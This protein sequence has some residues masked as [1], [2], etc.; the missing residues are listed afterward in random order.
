MPQLA[1][2]IVTVFEKESDPSVSSRLVARHVY[3]QTSSR[4]LFS[5]LID[6]IIF[7]LEDDRTSRAASLTWAAFVIHNTESPEYTRYLQ[8]LVKY[9]LTS[10]YN[11][12]R[13]EIGVQRRK[14]STYALMYTSIF[15]N[16]IKINNNLFDVIQEIYSSLLSQEMMLDHNKNELQS[17][18]I[19]ASKRHP[20]KMIAKKL[21]DD[22]IDCVM[23]KGSFKSTSLKQ[24]NPNEHLLILADRLRGTRRYVMQDIMNKRALHRKKQIEK[25]LSERLAS[26]ED[27]V[28]SNEPFRKGLSLFLKEKHYNYQFIAIEKIRVSLQIIG[29]LIGVVYALCGYLGIGGLHWFQGFV[30][31]AGMWGFVKVIGS[32]QQF[33]RFYPYDVTRELQTFVTIFSKALKSMSRDQLYQFL[34]S[35]A[36]A[37]ENE[38]FIGIIPEFIK[39]LY[40]LMPDRKNMVITIDQLAELIEGIEINIAKQIRSNL[41]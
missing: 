33:Q 7:L 26:A 5:H 30:I 18:N 23:A 8:E 14:Y 28:L 21:Y 22:V 2:R 25:E 34:Q 15:G 31:C 19:I 38:A 37:K 27:I 24:E 16:L 41:S 35:Q 1:L 40:A 6:T 9:T 29:I 12:D 11:L 10:Y 36:A 39:Y 13:P 17:N 4:Q 3:D 32:R 20:K